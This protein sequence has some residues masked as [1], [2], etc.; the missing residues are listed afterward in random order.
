MSNEIWKPSKPS[1]ADVQTLW[2]AGKLRW[3]LDTCQREIYDAYRKW[4]KE[5]Y[6]TR[7]RGEDIEGMYPRVFCLTH[8]YSNL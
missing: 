3:K 7:L 6:E 1:D 5:S 8:S 2:R 4:E